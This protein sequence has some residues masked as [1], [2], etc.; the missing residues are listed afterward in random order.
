[1]RTKNNN[2]TIRRQLMVT[3]SM[4]E[5]ILLEARKFGLSISSYL[6]LI[7]GKH[8]SRTGSM[9]MVDEKRV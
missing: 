1:M 7:L 5:K 9:I 4:D 6:E 8:F 3:E 2:R